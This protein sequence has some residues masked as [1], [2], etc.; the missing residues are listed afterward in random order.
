MDLCNANNKG[1]MAYLIKTSI[2]LQ[3]AVGA[4]RD[5]P[6]VYLRSLAGLAKLSTCTMRY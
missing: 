1:G 4:R 5:L 6:K 2:F 3:D